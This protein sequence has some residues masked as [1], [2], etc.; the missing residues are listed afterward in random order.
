MTALFEIA[1]LYRKAADELVN[2][3]LDDQV[4]ADTLEGL[5]GD[6]QQKATNVAFVAKNLEATTDAIDKAIDEMKRRKQIILGRTE[7]IREYLK[8]CMEV[9]QVTKIECPHFVLS[10]KKNP[11]KVVIDDESAI[12][13]D[14]VRIPDP[15]P[16]EIDKKA[17]ASAIKAGADIPGAH[18]EV[19]IRLEIK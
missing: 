10:I 13:S 7:R 4:I 5:G 8:N 15:P 14:F 1:T 12:P 19:A 2:L 11:P 3:D 17:I 6:L 9:A 16:P 18:M